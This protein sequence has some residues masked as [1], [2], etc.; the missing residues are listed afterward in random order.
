M[1]MMT[2][3]IR[4]PAVL[5]DIDG[6]LAHFDPEAVR[7]WVLGEVKMW[8]EFFAHMR[9]APVK[10]EVLRLVNILRA[11]G[12]TILLCSGRPEAYVEDTTAWLDLRGIEYD[13]LYLRKPGDDARLDED[14]KEEL[15]ATIRNDGY[16]PWLVIDDRTAVVNHWRHLGLC[17]LQCAPGDF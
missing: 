4:K 14:V 13:G 2:A 10:E 12:E 1:N 9:E 16:E 6:T 5:V 17:C 11:S 8:P 15:L 3:T 7:E